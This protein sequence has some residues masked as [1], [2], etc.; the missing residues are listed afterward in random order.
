MKTKKINI[1]IYYGTLI[2]IKDEDFTAV[3]KKYNHN[4]PES[5]GAVSFENKEAKN[6]EYVVVMVNTNISLIAHE[7]VHIC[8]FIF[9]NVGIELDRNNDEPQAYLVGWIVDE[10]EKFLKS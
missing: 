1:P 2:L 8:N 5:Y 4:I 9:K 10:I 6:F 7:A 3:N